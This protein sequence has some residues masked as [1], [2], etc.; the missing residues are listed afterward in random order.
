MHPLDAPVRL[1]L[2]EPGEELLG[3]EGGHGPPEVVRP[4]LPGVVGHTASRDQPR[5]ARSEAIRFASCDVERAD[6]FRGVTWSS[7][8]R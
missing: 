1:G 6:G 2:R 8:Q 3:P 5:A 4:E 7:A